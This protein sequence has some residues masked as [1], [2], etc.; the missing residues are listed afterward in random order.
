MLNSIILVFAVVGIFLLLFSSFFSI[1]YFFGTKSG[2]KILRQYIS[3]IELK[4]K[5]NPLLLALIYLIYIVLIGFISGGSYQYLIT[6]LVAPLTII[7]GI[8]VWQWQEDVKNK[9]AKDELFKKKYNEKAEDI[10]VLYNKYEKGIQNLYRLFS[11][12]KGVYTQNTAKQTDKLKEISL[13]INKLEK[14][15]KLISETQIDLYNDA[16][17]FFHLKSNDHNLKRNEI[18]VYVE[19]NNLLNVLYI[20]NYIYIEISEFVDHYFKM[21]FVNTNNY[22][23]LIGKY[24]SK[25]KIIESFDF[26]F[27]SDSDKVIFTKP[28]VKFLEITKNI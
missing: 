16:V 7:I 17:L 22:Y 3:K 8:F 5:I 9:T 18:N 14:E 13:I 4:I 20:Y 12:I 19:A 24:R 25:E 11:N 21:D 6:P 28:R 23:T 15:L 27:S 10:F 26:G 1:L 2:L